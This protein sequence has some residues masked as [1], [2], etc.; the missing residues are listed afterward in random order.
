MKKILL[1][2]LLGVVFI[3]LTGVLAMSVYVN[4]SI[5]DEG[6]VDPSMLALFYDSYEE[7]REEFRRMSTSLQERFDDVEVDKHIVKSEVDSDLS[8]D[9]VYVPAQNKP[10]KL[11]IVSSG[12]H[13]I[14]GFTGSAVQRFFVR[15]LIK[16]EDL[17]NI[18]I[19]LIHSV[20]P[21]GFKYG[22]RVSENGVD[23]NRNFDVS[24]T[25][26]DIGNEGYEKIYK[27]LNP[28]KKAK[29]GFFRNT[30]FF[31]KSVYH[32]LKYKM[33]ALR[34]AT[35]QGQYAF[36]NGVFYGGN[37]F[38]PQKE[39]IERLILDKISDYECIFLV[40]VHTGYGERGKLHFLPGEVHEETGKIL[41]QEMFEDFVIDWPVGNF[42]KVKGGFRD[43]VWNLIP[44]DKKYIGVVFEFGTLN[45]RQTVGAIRSL[46]NM[47]LENQGFQQGYKNSEAEK[48]VKDR[49]REMFFPSSEIWRSQIMKQVDEVLPVLIDRY[50]QLVL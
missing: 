12:I 21:Y 19:L 46:H 44:S 17:D 26:F 14:E 6:E 1:S 42:Y 39:W 23:M 36:K 33:E 4:K 43:Y 7:N 16:S 11:M 18:G 35:V 2:V 32:I 28:Q 3:V 49:F 41:L 30:F 45:S 9:T 47:V 22:R 48:R 31:I 38:E 40:D 34:Q 50:T 29:T 25:L 20:N 8:I 24:K 13:G 10:Q 15:E 37:N 5:V 27:F